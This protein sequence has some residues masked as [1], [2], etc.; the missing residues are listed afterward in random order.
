[1]AWTGVIRTLSLC[2]RRH[3]RF[4]TSSAVNS[5]NSNDEFVDKLVRAGVVSSDVVA[6]V[7]RQV[8]RRHYVARNAYV[9]SPQSIGHG[10][11]ISAPHM[12]A[13]CLQLLQD[14]LA[15][16]KRALDVGVGSGYLAACMAEMV[17]ASGRVVGI[18]VIVPLVDECRRNLAADGRADLP[19]LTVAVKDGW[20]GDADHAPYDAIHVGAAAATTPPALIEQ[21][22]VG[23]RLVIPVGPDGGNQHLMQYDKDADG[24][25]TSKVICG[26]RY[27]PLVQQEAK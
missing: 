10:V 13:M 7:M 20:L 8:D 23:G 1:M 24:N 2:H 17:G 15:P 27:V 22:A 16:G 12:H 26:V 5:A 21:L 25:I 14:R 11:T 6:N 3:R 19:Q 4:L 9:D 18:D